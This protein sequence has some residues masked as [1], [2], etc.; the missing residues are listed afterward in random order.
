MVNPKG[1]VVFNY[2]KTFLY[3]TDEVWGCSEPPVDNFPSGKAFPLTGSITVGEDTELKT[4]VGICMDLNPYKMY[5]SP[6]EDYNFATAAKK[7]DAN[8]VLVP[9]NWL[10]PKS[11]NIINKRDDADGPGE[12]NDE[13]KKTKLAQLVKEL[14]SD[15][16][17]MESSTL[18]YWIHRMTPFLGLDKKD[19]KGVAWA[20]SNRTGV[21]DLVVYAGTSSILTLNS[22]NCKHDHGVLYYGS[23][24]A[25]EENL[26]YREVELEV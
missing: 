22:S 23:L 24:G 2:W 25:L 16:T 17:E 5:E 12:V 1:S 8:L 6:F 4:Q 3:E 18:N 11:P 13:Y 21:E 10:H 19:R 14:E 7:N 26:L 20:V 9:S 15:P